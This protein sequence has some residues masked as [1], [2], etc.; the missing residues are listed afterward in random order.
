MRPVSESDHFFS[1]GSARKLFNGFMIII[2]LIFFVS[3]RARLFL[4]SPVNIVRLIFSPMLLND[5]LLFDWE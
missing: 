2:S 1:W 5:F 3:G 4:F